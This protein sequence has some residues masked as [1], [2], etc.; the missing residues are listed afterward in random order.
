MD[1]YKT[2]IMGGSGFLGQALVERLISMGRKNITSMSRNEGEA[3]K[4]KQKFPQ[5]QIIIGDICNP[6]DVK[7]AMHSADEVYLLSAMKHVGL[8]EAQVQA[9]VNTN[10]LGTMNVI[11]ESLITMPKVLVFISSD[12]AAQPN[13]VYG[14]LKKI[15]E[16]LLDEAEK[17]NPYTKYRVVRY[18]N[19]L[20]STGS[21]LCKWKEKMLAG[22]E[23]TVTDQESTRFYWPVSDAV[24]LIFTCVDLAVDSHPFIT[25]MKSMRLGDLLSAMMRKYGTVPIKTIGLQPGENMHEVIAEGIP[26]SYNSERYTQEEILKLI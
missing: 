18:G 10:I 8:A 1:Y 14:C 16:K 12:K 11:N 26:D 25:G 20:F 15:G 22:Q 9:C 21:V 13:G 3:V 19:V 24:D 7:R 6:W 17:N 5:V 23:V 2:L 4:L